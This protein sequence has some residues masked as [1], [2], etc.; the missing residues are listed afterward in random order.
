MSSADSLQ[1]FPLL[2]CALLCL[3]SLNQRTW[4]G[5]EGSML[6]RKVRPAAAP[7]AFLGDPQP[8]TTTVTF[9]AL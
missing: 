6:A 7:T 2:A 5:V 8:V 9:S 3:K 4:L 1:G